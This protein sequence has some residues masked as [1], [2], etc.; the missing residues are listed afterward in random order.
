MVSCDSLAE[1]R[2]RVMDLITTVNA[3]ILISR[4]CFVTFRQ[5]QGSV[6]L[7]K[8]ILDPSPDLALLASWMRLIFSSF[9]KL[10]DVYSLT[11]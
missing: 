8:D 9:L 7:F 5:Q 4:S 2:S 11:I 6:E 1:G 3:G 10:Q